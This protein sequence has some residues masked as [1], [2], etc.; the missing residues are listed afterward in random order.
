MVI[1]QHQIFGINTENWD[2]KIDVFF[3]IS[4][5]LSTVSTMKKVGCNKEKSGKLP[6]QVRFFFQET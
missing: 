2:S 5:W 6:S 3:T 4:N 1:N